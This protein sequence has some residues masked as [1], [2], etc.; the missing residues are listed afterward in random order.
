MDL[1]QCEAM[2]HQEVVIHPEEGL[3]VQ[4]V[5]SEAVHLHLVGMVEGEVDIRLLV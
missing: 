5:V 4:G 2:D 3:T 1:H